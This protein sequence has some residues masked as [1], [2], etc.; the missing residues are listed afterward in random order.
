MLQSVLKKYYGIEAIETTPIENYPCCKKDDQ[1]FLLVPV[2]HIDEEVLTEL[3]KMAADLRK[4]GDRTVSTFLQTKDQHSIIEVESNKYC[5]L[6]CHLTNKRRPI[7]MGRTLAKFHYLGRSISFPVRKLSRIGQWKTLWETRIDQMEKVWSSMF[8]QEPD[9]EFDRMFVESF[10]YYMALAENAMQYLVDTELDDEPKMFDYGTVC[11]IRF[12]NDIWNK[13]PLIKNPFHWVFDHAS[14]DLAEWT[15][16]KYLRNY[17]IYAQEVQP[18]FREYQMIGRLSP[19]SWRLLYAR[20]IFPLHY[21]E[22]I[23]NYYSASSEQDQ[24]LL[25]EQL[26]KHLIESA[27]YEKFLK[28]FYEL[29]EV[30]V[31]A[32]QIPRLDWL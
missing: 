11:H 14:R 30:P 28:Y 16:E 24:R 12:S 7:N 25:T 15:R 10:P 31:M 2:S 23:E 32:G 6:S 21:V 19:F 8:A 20:L 29:A 17:Q 18:F 4:R 13:E 9:C 3:E 22:C 5:V 1:R 26:E 27:E